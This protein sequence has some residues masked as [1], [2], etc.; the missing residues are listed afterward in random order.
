MINFDNFNCKNAQDLATEIT[1][2]YPLEESN[3]I[4]DKISDIYNKFCK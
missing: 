4:E 1:N 2:M 3:E